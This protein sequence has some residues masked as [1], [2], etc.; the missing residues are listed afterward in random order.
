MWIAVMYVWGGLLAFSVCDSCPESKDTASWVMLKPLEHCGDEETFCPYR[1]T[2]P[3][4]S[5]QLPR[6]FKELEK[7]AKELQNLKEAVNWLMRDCQECKDKKRVERGGQ[8]DQSEQE[9]AMRAQCPRHNITIMDRQSDIPSGE[10]VVGIITSTLGDTLS[11][12]NIRVGMKRLDPSILER[13]GWTIDRR[14]DVDQGTT[15]Q[16]SEMSREVKIFN[17]SFSE[18]PEDIYEAKQVLSPATDQLGE[19]IEPSLPRNQDDIQP[20]SHRKQQLKIL[21]DGNVKNISGILSVRR[22]VQNVLYK[23]GLSSISG[24][25]NTKTMD[26]SPSS[27][28]KRVINFPGVGEELRPKTYVNSRGAKV[29]NEDRLKN[30]TVVRKAN[31]QA[32]DRAVKIGP[33]RTGLSS[34]GTAIMQVKETNP[35]IADTNPGTSSGL[36]PSTDNQKIENKQ[37]ASRGLTSTIDYRQGLKDASQVTI[38]GV[39]SSRKLN[40]TEIATNLRKVYQGDMNQKATNKSISSVTDRDEQPNMVKEG[41]EHVGFNVS[42][43]ITSREAKNSTKASRADSSSPQRQVENERFLNPVKETETGKKEQKSLFMD[44]VN[45]PFNAMEGNP[46]ASDL[47][48]QR[49]SGTFTDVEHS[50]AAKEEIGFNSLSARTVKKEILSNAKTT[51]VGT[52]LVSPTLTP[53]VKS[54][55]STDVPMRMA[56]KTESLVVGQIS[57]RNS[58]PSSTFSPKAKSGEEGLNIVTL[59]SKRNISKIQEPSQNKMRSVKNITQRMPNLPKRPDRHPTTLI[60]FREPKQPNVMTKVS[61]NDSVVLRPKLS[62]SGRGKNSTGVIKPI[63]IRKRP[64]F[65]T[66]PTTNN[67]N[68]GLKTKESMMTQF[69]RPI[70]TTSTK[71]QNQNQETKDTIQVRG[72][73]V[74]ENHRLTITNIES[75]SLPGRETQHESDI[76]DLDTIKHSKTRIGEHSSD[77]QMISNMVNGTEN[78]NKEDLKYTLHS[79]DSNSATGVEENEQFSLGTADTKGETPFGVDKISGGRK[80]SMPQNLEPTTPTLM[81]GISGVNATPFMTSND[82]IVSI[83]DT[84]HEERTKNIPKRTNTH[85]EIFKSISQNTALTPIS[86]ENTG[87][88]SELELIK[89]NEDRVKD[90]SGEILSNPNSVDNVQGNDG[91]KDTIPVVL[92]RLTNV[93]E[94]KGAKLFS[95]SPEDTAEG[96]KSNAVSDE[97]TERDREENKLHSTCR[98]DC[99]TIPTEQPKTHNGPPFDSERDKRPA[100][101]C[102]DYITKTRK[103]GIYRVTPQSKNST[104]H[105]F[106]DMG[107]SNGGW[108]LIQRRFDGSTSFNRTWDEYKRGFG[109]LTGEFWLGNDK[110]HWLTKTKNM[111][112]RIELEDFKGIK[113]YALYKHFYVASESQQYRLSIDGYSGTAGNAMQFSKKYNHNQK[114]FS[115]PDRD[116]DQY[117]SG[118]CGA[119]YSSGWWFDACMSANL[120]GKYYNT[121][122]KG[123]RNGIFWGTWHNITMEYY[124]TN[125]RNSFK[126]VRMMVRPKNYVN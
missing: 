9:E 48:D 100:Q 114:L 91:E 94:I 95:L 43:V 24:N 46:L 7:M 42:L 59:N 108:T 29:S 113:E 35:Y 3:P 12:R 58:T 55:V 87:A 62:F 33:R 98:G 82:A 122:Y 27:E 10:Q 109:K 83:T 119:Y 76:I 14:T 77:K 25:A 19:S 71:E 28:N 64:T 112:L 75:K 47:K 110:I 101:D 92:E 60:P 97:V 96:F 32:G 99:D 68:R 40:K 2:L 50:E 67:P 74:L 54:S 34:E 23:N 6:P 70:G 73:N 85:V 57:K 20:T 124:P 84:D 106:C 90:Q 111:S 13:Q 15:D 30:P 52:D 79:G 72:A 81:K 65:Q 126:T 86:F 93:E 53:T 89:L 11:E 45:S 115:T 56:N 37:D 22:R 49:L 39:E 117:P 38:V 1:I 21:K 16:R 125:Y 103:N 102:A 51:L 88:T 80:M 41:N 104:F 17:P 63:Y 116:N 18:S 118:N 78:Q 26:L 120:N 8:K 5:I 69:I 61:V 123:V 31:P 107:S 121:K 66:V 44:R 4:L 105:V 36:T